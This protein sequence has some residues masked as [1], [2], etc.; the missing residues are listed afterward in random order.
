MLKIGIVAGLKTDGGPS[1]R[2]TNVLYTRAQIE[3]H[4]EKSTALQIRPNLFIFVK[5]L[6]RNQ[7]LEQEVIKFRARFGQ[8][9]TEAEQIQLMYDWNKENRQ[10]GPSLK[11]QHPDWRRMYAYLQQVE[12]RVHF[13]GRLKEI[14]G[15]LFPLFYAGVVDGGKVLCDKWTDDPITLRRTGGKHPVVNIS[16]RYSDVTK[17]AITDYVETHWKD[18]SALLANLAPSNR[19]A[20]SE[21]D[22]YIVRLRD[23]K[24]RKYG[25]IAS[26][27]QRR[28]R[29]KDSMDD[30]AVRNAYQRAKAIINAL[31]T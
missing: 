1:A 25:D 21:R 22:W 30:A 13:T 5:L 15:N 6:E 24:K 14:A 9:S 26:I 19:Y 23:D 7:L 2:Y 28:Y 29:S 18:I 31:F 17:N 12:K 4:N 20:I 27:I 16:I 10:W 8:V 11:R 3:A